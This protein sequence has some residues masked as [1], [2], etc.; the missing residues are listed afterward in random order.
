MVAWSALARTSDFLWVA[1]TTPIIRSYTLLVPWK[2]NDLP[3]ISELQLPV[4][5]H[6]PKMKKA[7][8]SMISIGLMIFSVLPYNAFK[9]Q[10][11]GSLQPAFLIAASSFHTYR[12]AGDVIQSMF[13]FCWHRN[14]ATNQPA[15]SCF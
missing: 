11:D 1:A 9:N 7:G 15:L 13:L 3:V 12:T 8:G 14:T 2:S 4:T 5:P 10:A 6:K